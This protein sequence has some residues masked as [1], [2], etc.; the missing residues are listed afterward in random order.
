M[1]VLVGDAADG[2]GVGVQKMG[3]GV[4]WKVEVAARKVR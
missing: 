4:L 1:S 3:V 2:G